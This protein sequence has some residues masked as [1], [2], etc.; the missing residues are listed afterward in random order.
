MSR[1]IDNLRVHSNKGNVFVDK[2]EVLEE[3]INGISNQGTYSNRFPSNYFPDNKNSSNQSISSRTSTHSNFRALKEQRER[4]NKQTEEQTKHAV[5][6]AIE[7]EH[8]RKEKLFP[9]LMTNVNHATRFLDTVDKDLN[10]FDETKRNKTRRQFEDWNTNVHGNI[11]KRIAK[12]LNDLDSKDLNKKKNEDYEK[13]LNITNRKP[14]I[15]NDII[16]ESE[17]DPLEPNRRCI[18]AKTGKLKDPVKIDAQKAE[19]ESSMLGIKKVKQPLGKETLPVELWHSGK[20]EAT[21]YGSFA[22][23]MNSHSEDHAKKNQTMK[24]KVV[25]DHFNYPS[26][27]DAIDKEMPVGKR[28]YPLT[29]YADPTRVGVP[30]EIQKQLL[31]IKPPEVRSTYLN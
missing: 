25:F 22:K 10:L 8:I 17:Y 5:E 13:F 28:C 18:K 9:V 6:R 31:E 26:G 19:S 30:L 20:I 14:A 2:P 4:L 29:I 3:I 7:E 27:K 15:F 21:P 16:I 1:K 23:L 12:T 24:S 11:Q